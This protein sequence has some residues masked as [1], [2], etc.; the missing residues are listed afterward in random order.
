MLRVFALRLFACRVYHLARRGAD[1]STAVVTCPDS[2]CT[3]CTPQQQLLPLQLLGGRDARS[4]TCGRRWK[5]GARRRAHIVA[6]VLSRASPCTKTAST[7]RSRQPQRAEG[8]RRT[9]PRARAKAKC[10]ARCTAFPIALKDNVHTTDMPTTGGAVAFEGLM[11]PYDATLT[12]NLRDAGA[13][14]IAKTDAHRAG[15]LGGGRADA[16][17][18]QLQRPQRLRAQPLRPAPRSAPADRRRPAR[19]STPAA[20]ARAPARRSTSGRPTSAPRRRD[21]S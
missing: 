7:P 5:R 21:R 20:R 9:R 19:C 6:A 8:S 11:P 16:D 10:A 12:K 17:A 13:I 1:A 15:Q 2:D 4:P 14:I 18:G 3:A